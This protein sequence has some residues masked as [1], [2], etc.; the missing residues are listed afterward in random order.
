MGIHW[1]LFEAT[2]VVFRHFKIIDA[3]D[4][5][6]YGIWG[7]KSG[8]RWKKKLSTLIKYDIKNMIG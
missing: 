7:T 3:M 2:F 6:K 4:E 5:T 8:Y 1:K